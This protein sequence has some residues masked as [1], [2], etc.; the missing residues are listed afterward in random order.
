MLRAPDT[1]S[2]LF[3]TGYISNDTEAE[4]LRSAEGRQKIAQGVARAVAIY[5]ATLGH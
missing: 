5:A 2:I 1:P 4:R 3:E